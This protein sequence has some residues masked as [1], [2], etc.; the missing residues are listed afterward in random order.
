M[1]L[2]DTLR[3]RAE[4]EQLPLRVIL[5]EALQVYTLAAIYGQPASDR[6][7]FQGGTC[8]RLVY[9]GPRYSEDVDFVTTLD[10][11]ELAALF[12]PVSREVA[13]LAPLFDGEITAR[14]QK[15]T[16]EIA[17]WRVRYRAAREQDSTSISLEFAPYP[18]YTDHAAVL[19][20][21]TDLPALPLVVVRA[22]ALEEIMADKVAAFAGRRYVKG[23]DVFDLWWLKGKGIAVDR[24]LVRKK[25]ADYGVQPER[26][27]ANLAALRLARVR[28]ELENFLPLRYRVQLLRPDV[29]EAMVAG[30]RGLL[31]EVVP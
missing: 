2:L 10:S 4:E 1:A 3:E 16:P 15:A 17:C 6:I 25:L 8:L 31:E 7:T 13:R 12:E 27:Q 11:A 28:Q 23:R 14:V 19:R 5:K 30:V 22:E 26:L 24:E 21:S 29:L 18:A 9:G 20:P